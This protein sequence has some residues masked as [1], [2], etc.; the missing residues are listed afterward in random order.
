MKFLRSP[1]SPLWASDLSM[2]FYTYSDSPPPLWPSVPS[3]ASF[4]NGPLPSMASVPCMAVC[5]LYGLLPPD[6]SLPLYDLLSPST[7][8]NLLY[9]PLSSL[10]LS[11]SSKTLCAL[12]CPLSPQW[13]LSPLQ[14]CIFSTRHVISH[15]FAK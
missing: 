11:V 13:H 6:S 5:P 4:L 8:L 14:S 12:Y 7:A 10:R 9:G 2:T 1:L 3:L 15:C